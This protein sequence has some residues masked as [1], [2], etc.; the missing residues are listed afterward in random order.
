MKKNLN[1]IKNGGKGTFMGNLLRG[2]VTV[3]KKVSPTLNSL[4]SA[5]DGSQKSIG[6]I[7]HQ[8][9]KEDISS[10]DLVFLLA[11]LDKDKVELEQITKRWVSDNLGSWLS[12]NVRPITLLLYNFNTFF[13]IYLD[14]YSEVN[15]QVKEMWINILLTNTGL[16]NTAYFG[17]RYLEKRDTKKFK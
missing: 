16:I 9:K 17:S 6:H 7:S 13:L 11:E 3:G 4:L 12:R 2:I 14:S 10:N 15:F 8:L 5:F 1:Q